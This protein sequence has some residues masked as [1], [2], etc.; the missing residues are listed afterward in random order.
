MHCEAVRSAGLHLFRELS[1][2]GQQL[3]RSLLL[4][5]RLGRIK[6]MF[7][8]RMPRPPFGGAVRYSH[9]RACGIFRYCR[10][11]TLRAEHCL[12]TGGLVGVSATETLH[13]GPFYVL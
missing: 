6:P 11:L 8:A 2:L 13:N 12:K 7:P 5:P 9:R 1:T 3:A 4:R 10:G